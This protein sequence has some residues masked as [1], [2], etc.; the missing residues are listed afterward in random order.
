MQNEGTNKT[1][2]ACQ[3]WSFL[4]KSEP[5]TEKFTKPRM[6]TFIKEKL[7]LDDH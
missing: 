7:K 6:T 4:L 2:Q 1:L 5:T 3:P